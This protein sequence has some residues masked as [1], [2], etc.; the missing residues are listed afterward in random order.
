MTVVH[1]IGN[2]HIDPVWLWTWQAGVDETLA[3]LA[4]AIRRCDEYPDFI[5]T[6]GEAWVYRQA[7]TLRPDLFARIQD[8]VRAGRWSIAGGTW[9]QPD[10][11]LPTPFA[12]ERQIIHGQA[13]F[14]R[15]FGI[16]PRIAFNLDCFGHPATLPDLFAAHGYVGY[17]LGRPEPRQFPIPYNAFLWRGAGGAELPAFRVIDGYAWSADDLGEHVQ[18]ALA[19]ADPALGHTMC[20]YGVG[21]HG[22]GP[23]MAQI[24]WI[25]AHRHAIAGVELRLSTPETFFAAIA[26]RHARLPVVQ[27][28]MQHC[29]PG[30]YSVMSDIKRAQR[31]G[32]HLLDQA[33]RAAQAFAPDET[34]RARHFARLDVAWEDLL[35]TA[36][37]DIVTGTSIPSAWPSVRA[38]QGRAHI[39]AEETIL[40]VTRGWAHRVLGESPS[41]RLVFVNPHDTPFQDHV[42]AEA[43]L[44]YEQWGE[45][46]LATPEGVPIAY[47]RVQPEAMH[48]VPRLLFDLALPPCGA[49]VVE[50]RPGRGPAVPP[51]ATDLDVSPQRLANSQVALRLGPSGIESLAF[52]GHDLLALT[53]HLREDNTDTW[54]FFTDRWSEPVRESLAGGVWTVEEAGPL[55][56]SARLD[57]RLGTSRLRWTVALLRHDP[58]VF[59]RLE[60]NFDE[61]LTLLQLAATLAAP[62][63]K[64][65]DSLGG[66]PVARP[67][68]AAEY[69]VQGWSRLTLPDADVA[70]VTQDA[71]SHSVDDT[72]WQ[73]TLMRS[74]R[75]AWAG[76]DPPVYHGH[77]HF[78]DQGPHDLRFVLHLGETLDPADLDRAALHLAQK[79]IVF[80]HTDGMRRP[81]MSP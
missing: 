74:P 12:L 25:L 45:R 57:A 19:H 60:I 16:S 40:E 38:R 49:R 39:V 22:G 21:D 47:Q 80:E 15:R 26:D 59:L 4:S 7:E 20:F 77:D 13:Y 65:T 69:P 68:S 54:A 8:L 23:T 37:H 51:P 61:R 75:M 3:T 70:L 6:R 41:H 43:W 53:L 50:I 55:R 34:S 9:L 33:A 2:A 28:E 44:D 62:P 10:L 56:A 14:Q 63:V 11:N 81:S 30:C 17:V 24:E 78:T 27:G 35:F 79:P 73:W 29:F 67:M 58:R 66:A 46:W 72:N 71:N 32:E 18:S 52:E 42:E 5:F 31:Q 64:R 76:G 1:M 48:L 36:F